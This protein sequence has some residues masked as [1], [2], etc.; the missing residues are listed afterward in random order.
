MEF[1]RVYLIIS[2][3]SDILKAYSAGGFLGGLLVKGSKSGLRWAKSI[4]LT[5]GVI[6]LCCSALFGYV[7]MALSDNMRLTDNDFIQYL[8]YS[9]DSRLLELQKYSTVLELNAINTKLKQLKEPVDEITP[10]M[11]RLG[12]QVLSY[13]ITNKIV[14]SAFMY[15][16]N[17]QIIVG[18]KGCYPTSSYYMLENSLLK[19]GYID[20]LADLE[21]MTDELMWVHT[22][23]DEKFCYGRRMMYEGETVG[24]IVFEIDTEEL[25]HATQSLVDKRP[26]RFGFGVMLDE[27]LLAQTTDTDEMQ[28]LIGTLNP[29]ALTSTSFVEQDGMI[30]YIRPSQFTDFYYLNAY[31]QIQYMRPLLIALCVCT[32]GVLVC[33]AFGLFASIYISRRNTKPLRSIIEKLGAAQDT[34]DEYQ[35]ISLCIDKMMK[36]KNI[37]E[38]KM[39]GQQDK[40]GAL[41]LNVVLAGEFQSEFSV[42]SMAKRYDVVFENP[43]YAIAVL[44]VKG[45]NSE[46]AADTVRGRILKWCE[47]EGYDVIVA[48]RHE[49]YILLFN[50]DEGISVK[51]IAELVWRMTSSLFGEKN[52]CAALG[53]IYDSLVQIY[54]SYSQALTALRY[55]TSTHSSSVCCYNS[56]MESDATKDALNIAVF[57]AFASALQQNK[58]VSAKEALP[59][60]F[61]KYFS[62][63]DS[64]DIR[65]IKFASVQNLL[66]DALIKA[67]QSEMLSRDDYRTGEILCC[68]TQAELLESAQKLLALLCEP[69]QSSTEPTTSVAERAKQII[70][71]DYTDPMLGLYM[72]SDELKVSNSYLSTTFKNKFGIGVVQYINRLRIDHAKEL[73]STTDMSIKDIALA[74]GFSSDISFIR[75]FKRYELQTPSTLRRTRE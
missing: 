8:Q 24:Y 59:S 23:S 60:L 64:A 34:P 58:F 40:I 56:L 36:E 67:R 47:S 46:A 39:H 48:Y 4:M 14:S 63:E 70:E 13:K 11:Y 73:I 45:E 7:L 17:A 68:T 74:A 28:K 53:H 32:G 54:L 2:P 62:A 50:V 65:R 69:V 5:V 37:S 21:N 44:Y 16:P 18:D 55:A 1:D 42:F 51:D 6:L 49:K 52:A 26:S 43:Y 20:W 41:F 9:V 33:A 10:D 35:A 71:R 66:L 30:L 75:V 19:D 27:T 22:S 15:Y 3:N 29:A 38:E 72:I 12:D 57:E 25:L 31:S 61:E